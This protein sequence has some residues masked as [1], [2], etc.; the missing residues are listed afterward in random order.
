MDGGA[1]GVLYHDANGV[2]VRCDFVGG[3]FVVGGWG[4]VW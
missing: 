1:T 2:G 3:G 4:G